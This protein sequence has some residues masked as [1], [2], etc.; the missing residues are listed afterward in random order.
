LP[1]PVRLPRERWLFVGIRD[2][3]D[4]D[5]AVCDEDAFWFL[6]DRNEWLADDDTD[7]A[8][9]RKFFP[10]ATVTIDPRAYDF[11]REGDD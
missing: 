8:P 7:A 9:I 5:P 10:D 6:T 2:L 3:P 1:L 11:P 4:A